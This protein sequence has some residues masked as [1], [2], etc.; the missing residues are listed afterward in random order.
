MTL[1]RTDNTEGFNQ[2]E[3]NMFNQ[4]L[5]RIFADP[6]KLERY[7]INDALNRGIPNLSHN[8][9]VIEVTRKADHER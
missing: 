6:G 7:S 8:R 1:W 9:P 4:V 3:L 2:S 5:E